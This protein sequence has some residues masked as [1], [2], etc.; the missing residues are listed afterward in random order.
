[1]TN[2]FDAVQQAVV[3]YGCAIG[4]TGWFL[5]AG[6]QA[7]FG[8]GLT[9]AA[10]LG[11]S[12]AAAMM[13]N[14]PQLFE[15]PANGTIIYESDS[16]WSSKLS[17]FRVYYSTVAIAARGGS[18]IYDCEAINGPTVSG[19]GSE[20]A[21]LNRLRSRYRWSCCA[22]ACD[23]GTL[24]L[25]VAVNNNTTWGIPGYGNR[26]G[27]QVSGVCAPYRVSALPDG[28]PTFPKP[29]PRNID[30]TFDFGGQQINAP[31]TIEAPDFTFEQNGDIKLNFPVTVN[32]GPFTLVPFQFNFDVNLSTGGSGGPGTGTPD[33]YGN[34]P[35]GGGPKL[36]MTDKDKIQPPASFTFDGQFAKKICNLD[37]TEIVTT[38]PYGGKDF[39]GVQ[40]A[41]VALNQ[42]LGNWQ[43]ETIDC[44][45]DPEPEPLYA[46]PVAQ[47]MSER[48]YKPQISFWF[49]ES[50]ESA[51]GRGATWRTLRSV[52]IPCRDDVT[53]WQDYLD[54]AMDVA[55]GL[56]YQAGSVGV[57]L[58]YSMY[59]GR[60]NVNAA[61]RD[62]GINVINALL[63]AAELPTV[64]AVDF[65]FTE[66][67]RYSGSRPSGVE[68]LTVPVSL[69]KGTLSNMDANYGPT[70]DLD[71]LRVG[72]S[73]RA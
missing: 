59:R 51:K 45:Q 30:I 54:S 21:P 23:E 68:L 18:P 61:T 2:F 48:P 32:A 3:D 17:T 8:S 72:R 7:A 39:A 26:G 46:I 9:A 60:Y 22:G 1:M 28:D 4:P 27:Y 66:G 19:R 73:R 70:Y 14:K 20:T 62:E 11:A 50:I 31:I 15:A 6:Q 49:I 42:V 40:S 41:L 34:P 65:T 43:E 57:A 64:P 58:P 24:I 16:G 37:G 36:P 52:S 63:T 10:A 13:C 29:P 5:I 38:E 69:W 35:A 33:G 55:R 67:L 53:D 47:H 71:A 56:S 12:A 25:E 44:S